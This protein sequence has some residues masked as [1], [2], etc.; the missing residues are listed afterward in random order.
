MGFWPFG[1]GPQQPRA[2]EALPPLPPV[3]PPEPAAS[4]GGSRGYLGKV[5]GEGRAMLDADASGFEQ[6]T[7]RDGWAVQRKPVMGTKVLRP[8]DA[9]YCT[10]LAPWPPLGVPLQLVVSLGCCCCHPEWWA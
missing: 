7:A 6:I 2:A 10:C 5:L 4:N 9:C 1:G 3:L 8:G